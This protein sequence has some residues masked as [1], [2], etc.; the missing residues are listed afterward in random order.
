MLKSSKEWICTVSR[1]KFL[2]ICIPFS[3]FLSSFPLYLALCALINLKCKLNLYKIIIIF[4]ENLA[5]VLFQ[6]FQ[7]RKQR[8]DTQTNLK[9]DRIYFKIKCCKFDQNYSN[10]KCG[11]CG[12]LKIIEN[13]MIVTRVKKR[14]LHHIFFTI[15]LSHLF[16]L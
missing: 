5:P 15:Y 2:C 13:G 14:R 8:T 11:S 6:H 4:N 7:R 1:L 12:I 3:I 10:L 16:T 9:S